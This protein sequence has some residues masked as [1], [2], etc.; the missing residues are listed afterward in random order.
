MALNLTSRLQ[1]TAHYFWNRRNAAALSHHGVRLEYDPEQRRS[2]ALI[3]GIT[4]TLLAVA[5]MFVLSWFKPAGQVGKS[6][7]LA[8][9]DT[10]A[11]YV[12]VDGRLHPALNLASARLIAGQ[13]NNPTF[14][15]AAELDK[16]PQGPTVGIVGAPAAMPIRTGDASQWAVCDTAPAATATSSAGDAPVVTAIAGPLTVGLRSA[17]LRMPRAILARYNDKTYVIWDG[18]RSEIDLSNKAVALALG[19]DSTAPDPIPLSKALFDALPATDPLVSPPVPQAGQPSP[20]NIAP[21]AV[22]GSVLQA[23]DLAQPGSM[24]LYVLLPN[25]VQRISPFVA[26]L[27]RSANSFGDVAPIEVAPDK[28]AVVPVVES[29]PVSFYPT[30]RLELVDTTVDG[31]TCLAWSKGSTDRSAEIT[32]LSGQGLPI[33][34][35]ADRNLIALVKNVRDPNAV[36]ADRVYLAPGSTNLVMTTSAAPAANSRESLWWISDQ[37]VRYGI[38]LTEESLRALGVSPGNAR[39]APWPLIRV[40]APGPA[41]TRADALTQHDTLTPLVGAEALP[42]QAAA[43]PG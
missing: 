40:F 18:H 6:N 43:A 13:A 23:R 1:V 20:W 10:G 32:V 3:L 38:E 39:Q 9:R 5:L 12:M 27:L 37:G 8:D 14:V 36:E 35:G 41:L 25:G 19:V 16:Y 21:G 29:L 42:T 17:P 24:T 30:T 7:I 26:S 28:L 34:S 31:T 22:I 11:V 4:F 15:K 2:A 33:P